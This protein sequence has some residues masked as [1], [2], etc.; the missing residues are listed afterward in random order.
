MGSP[1]DCLGSRLSPGGH[2]PTRKQDGRPGA[3]A[4]RARGGPRQARESPP[5]LS[6]HMRSPRPAAWLPRRTRR[7]RGAVLVTTTTP[8]PTPTPT[9]TP[10]TMT[11]T[12]AERRRA[13]AWAAP[14]HTLA[15][16]GPIM[17][18]AAH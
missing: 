18:Q 1:V 3:V 15:I 10:T 16:R 13:P 17:S 6:G 12:V 5:P 7:R 14:R 4:G 2:R 8:P 11:M 9:P